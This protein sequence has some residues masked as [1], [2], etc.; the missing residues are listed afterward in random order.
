[1]IMI[2]IRVPTKSNVK[3]SNHDEQLFKLILKATEV[4]RLMATLVNLP[5]DA[6][7]LTLDFVLH[8]W[9]PK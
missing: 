6:T 9:H 8:N 7:E 2:N 1:M 4:G 5:A 3:T